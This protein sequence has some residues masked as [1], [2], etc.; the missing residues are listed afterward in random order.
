MHRCVCARIQSWSVRCGLHGGDRDL[1]SKTDF[2]LH[3]KHQ[4]FNIIFTFAVNYFGYAAADYPN[5]KSATAV[6]DSTVFH[7]T[8]VPNCRIC[9]I[10][11]RA[12]VENELRLDAGLEICRYK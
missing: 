1:T 4:P 12:A 11:Q 5:K 2:R 3:E 10:F 8:I 6:K 7:C 9:Y